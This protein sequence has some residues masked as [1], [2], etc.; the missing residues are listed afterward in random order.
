MSVV[1]N[2]HEIRRAKQLV[3]DIEQALLDLN[4]SKKLL[5]KSQ[6]LVRIQDVLCVIDLSIDYLEISLSQQKRIIEKGPKVVEN[7]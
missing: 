1:V 6:N 2:I 7:E 3:K 5:T 4:E